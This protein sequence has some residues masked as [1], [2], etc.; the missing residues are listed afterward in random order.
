MLVTI[1]TMNITIS[2]DFNRFFD[3]ICNIKDYSEA[4]KKYD[5]YQMNILD[6]VHR[7]LAK[8]LIYKTRFCR[9]VQPHDFKSYIDYASRIVDPQ[10][11]HEL[12]TEIYNITEDPAQVNT[13]LRILKNKIPFSDISF[14]Q[15]K[16]QYAQEISKKCPHCHTI[17]VDFADTDYVICGY[18]D[19]K[20]G[21]DWKG[22][23]R[24]WCF[25]CGK[26]LCKTWN[27]N[28]LNI[29]FNQSHDDR[30]C[31][32]LALMKG[33]NYES[34]FCNCN[35]NIHVNRS[36]TSVRLPWASAFE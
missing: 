12:I 8:S 14:I 30:C 7:Q 20:R 21:Y 26:R 35:N 22:C 9:R 2:K 34:E 28:K 13:M 33:L 17:R 19:F 32:N 1:K 36:K 15:L 31:K 23:G 24:D 3:E 6:D 11:A 27:K 18:G 4:V 25:Q 10:Q 29:Q 5:I 16:D